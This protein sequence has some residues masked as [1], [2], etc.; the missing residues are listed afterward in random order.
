MYTDT[1]ADLLTRIRNG[2]QG[3]KATVSVPHS[4]QKEAILKVM[5]ANGFISNFVTNNLD[6]NKKEI[7]I[8]LDLERHPIT[9]ERVSKPGQRIYVK[10]SDLKAVQSGLGI[11]I[12]STSK[13]IMTG[14]EAKQQKLGGELI[15]QIY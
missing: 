15:C 5:L 4:E 8:D 1:I 3:R 13:G 10:A 7:V 11:N 6:N 12:I 14:R 2:Q 9:L